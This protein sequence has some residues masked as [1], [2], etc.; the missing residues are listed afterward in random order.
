MRLFYRDTRDESKEAYLDCYRTYLGGD[1]PSM[2][3]RPVLQHATTLIDPSA[4]QR[5]ITQHQNSFD[6]TNS[7]PALGR[8]QSTLQP[9]LNFDGEKNPP[10]RLSAANPGMLRSRS[11]FGT[12]TLWEREMEKLKQMEEA[13]RVAAEEQ[14]KR[15][16]EEEAMGIQKKGKK[17]KKDKGKGK[18][19]L[20]L[21]VHSTSPIVAETRSPEDHTPDEPSVLPEV[22]RVTVR[23]APP[24]PGDNDSESESEESDAAG[25][26]PRPSGE[27]EG[28]NSSDDEAGPRRTTGVGPRYPKAGSRPAATQPV[29][30]DSSEEDV[31]LAA[32]ISRVL[33]R[34]TQLAPPVE[35][36]SDEEKPLS[37][38]LDK[39]KISVPT[40]DFDRPTASTS[41]LKP[42]VDGD[43]DDDE[44]PLGLRASTLFPPIASARGPEEDDDVPLG[45]HPEQQR[46]SHYNLLAQQQQMQMQ[47]QQQ[48]MFQAQAMQSMFFSPPSVMGSGFFNPAMAPPPMAPPMMMAPPQL[49]SPPP[50]H[51][52]AKLNRVDRWRREVSGGV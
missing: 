6:T 8:R 3:D 31:P 25:P 39:A 30:D 42:L 37:T 11:V 44:Q 34:T 16:E 50:L 1:R 19:Q 46:R 48:A 18:E 5:P 13:D 49:P 41:A 4:L 23:R 45:L 32:T 51:D 47:Q 29:G 9:L 7:A 15:E 12:D 20:S 14:R 24:P 21:Q 10:P 38:L 40:I 2:M 17:S 43:D 22:Q 27:V 33:Q 52:A 28:W 35:D 36:D 26:A